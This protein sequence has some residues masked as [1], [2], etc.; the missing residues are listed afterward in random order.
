[1][2]KKW[3]EQA[4]QAQQASSLAAS[5]NQLSQSNQF[6]GLGQQ[7]II[8]SMMAARIKQ[9]EEQRRAEDD[10][11]IYDALEGFLKEHSIP[12]ESYKKVAK[13]LEELLGLVEPRDFE[14]LLK[15]YELTKAFNDLKFNQKFEELVNE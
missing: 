6:Q 4:L 2:F 7:Q 10:K 9:L 14:S 3:I 15:V 1:M 13:D 11:R 5:Q 12:K 8:D